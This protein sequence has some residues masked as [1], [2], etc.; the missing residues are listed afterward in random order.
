MGAMTTQPT[1]GGDAGGADG[2][3][4]RARLMLDLARRVTGSLDLQEVLDASFAA[5]RQL[6][7]FG[8]GAIQLIED[9]HLVAAATD[10]P[11]APEAATVRI[12]VGAGVSGAIAATGEP[13][14]IP[15]ITV[16][17]RVHPDGRARGVSTGVRSYFG[18]PLIMG[19]API[20][21]LQVDALGVDAFDEDAR[22]LVLA[23]VPTIASA[24]QN[25]RLFDQEREALRRLEEVQRLKDGFV[26]IV[27]HEL[28]TPMATALGFAETLARHVEQLDPDEVVELSTRILSAGRRLQRLLEDLLYAA[29]LEQGFLEVTPVPTDVVR[30][31]QEVLVED[32]DRTHPVELT[33]GEGSTT[34]H[35]DPQ[36]LHQMVSN[37]VE[38][39]IKFSPDDEPVHVHVTGL[40]DAVELRVEDR[41]S[42]IPAEI[43]DDVFRLFFQAEHFT[44]RTVGGLGIGLH[45]V[46]RLCDAMDVEVTHEERAGGGTRFVLRIPRV[47]TS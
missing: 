14:Y 29:D 17:E 41:G 43:Q 33:V 39:A 12:P 15:D 28:R 2:H 25:A 20:G 42:G 45:V 18:V 22:S 24:V 26:S 19:G 3:V 35:V 27:S 47:A 7:D 30:V 1:N 9:D 13:T 21:V 16:D 6:V 11:M 36:R 46:R 44:T 34:A 31:C 4:D 10:P 8:G 5:L 23:F 40:P 38:N 37:L 32:P